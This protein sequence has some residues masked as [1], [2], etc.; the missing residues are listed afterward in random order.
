MRVPH[1]E[2]LATHTGLESCVYTRKGMGE[3]LTGGV[4]VRLLSRER[5]KYFG[6]PTL[7][8]KAEGNTNH[9]A[10]ARCDSALRGQRPCARTQ[11]LCAGTGRSHVWPCTDGGKARAE[12]PNGVRQR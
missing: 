10:I 8:S 7:S 2:G 9:I 12:N 4:R 6:V 1:G 5:R 11:A 3:A